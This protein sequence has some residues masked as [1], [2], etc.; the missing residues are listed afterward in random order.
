MADDQPITSATAISAT[1]TKSAIEAHVFLP[2]V[3]L[4]AGDRFPNFFLPDQQGAVRSF[5]ERAKGNAIALFIDA[6]DKILR[7]AIDAGAAF[8]AAQLDRIAV[9]GGTEDAVAARAGRLAA[10]FSV[11]ADP[12]DKI[13]PQLRQMTGMTGGRPFVVLLDRQQRILE[14]ADQGDL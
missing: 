4:C 9:L 5:V 10:N 6:D 7:Q 2:P 12:A 14:I 8:D 3:A 13:R 11:L 1:L